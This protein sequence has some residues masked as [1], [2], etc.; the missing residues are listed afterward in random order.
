MLLTLLEKGTLPW[1]QFVLL[2][3]DAL[4]LVTATAA[5]GLMWRLGLLRRAL[6]RRKR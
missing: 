4:V 6:W 5:L 2:V 1:W 3:L